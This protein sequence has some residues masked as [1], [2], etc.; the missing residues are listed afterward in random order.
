[1][2]PKKTGFYNLDLKCFKPGEDTYQ[3]VYS[4]F[5]GGSRRIPDLKE[6]AKTSAIDEEVRFNLKYN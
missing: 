3:K 1:M 2:I 6:I 5:L 4:F